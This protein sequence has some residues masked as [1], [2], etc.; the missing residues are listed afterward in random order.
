V[1]VR[2]LQPR[3]A[4]L[5][6]T[7]QVA[8]GRRL[9]IWVD[10]LT[11]GGVERLANA[12]VSMVVESLNDTPIIAERAMYLS[13]ATQ[14]FKAGHESAGVTAPATSWFF[15]EGATGSYFD[16][17]LLVGNVSSREAQLR[18]TYLLPDGTSLTKD[19]TVPPESRFNIWVDNETFGPQGLALADTAVATVLTSLNDVP[20]VAERAMWWPGPTSATWH[21]AHV[22]VGATATGTQ[23]AVADG[24]VGGAQNSDTYLLVANTGTTQASVRVTLLFESTDRIERTLLVAPQSRFNVDVRTFFPAARDRRF[25]AIVES[26]GPSPAPIVVE[27][28]MYRDSG[29]AHWAAGTGTLAV[30]VR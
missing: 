27:R 8:A 24:E 21:E 22:A 1:R 23:W 15:A 12:D 2:F 9:T 7:W 20:V 17:F 10:R 3:A 28:A 19:Y 25:G 5:E 26:L 29:A 30:R 18:A 13:T 14:L 16:L 4:P 6:R 11:F